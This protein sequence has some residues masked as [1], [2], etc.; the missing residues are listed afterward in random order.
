MIL[1][2]FDRTRDIAI[3]GACAVTASTETAIV[4]GNYL[5]LNEPPWTELHGYWDLTLFLTVPEDTLSG[6]LTQRWIKH[7]LSPAVARNR[8][9]DNDIP[10]AE[11]VIR[12]S[13][14]ADIML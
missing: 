5:L 13:V 6:R 4:E 8:A 3:A 10:N 12:N 9:R 7:G 2:V 14:P 1:P 11:R